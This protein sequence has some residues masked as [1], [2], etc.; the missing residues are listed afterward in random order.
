M[1][2]QS[3]VPTERIVAWRRH[4]HQNPELSHQEN[5]TAAYIL[6]QLAQ[7][8]V[9]RIDRPT[10]TSLIATIHGA[11]PGKT[12][13]FRADIDALPIEEETGLPFRS[14]VPGVMHACGHDG[15]AA[16]LLG[17]A[18]ML[19]RLRDRFR[20]TAKLLF[21]HAEEVVPSGASQIIETGALE[22]V[23]ACFGMHLFPNEIPGAIGI[24]P[25]GPASSNSD[26][27]NVKI[28]GKGTHGSMPHQGVDPIL[29]ASEIILA[30]NTIV[31]RNISPRETAVVSIGAIHAGSA[32]N[33]IPDLAEIRGNTR[34][35]NPETRMAIKN[36]IESIIR[37]VCDANDAKY[38]LDFR[39]GVESIQNDAELAALAGDAC[40]KVLGE[41]MV[42]DAAPMLA[43]EDF[44]FYSRIVPTCFIF[45]GAGNEIGGRAYANHHPK[46]DI[47]EEALPLGSLAQVQIILDFLK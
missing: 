5:Q 30:L 3:S 10:A 35:M 37:S 23:D 19:C 11:G 38:E 31:S 6:E 18:D 2:L 1:D 22:G 32:N 39:F 24:V 12:A 17:T 47:R 4:I 13:L 40:R 25:S 41:E 33:I 26:L 9:D 36:R 45:L 15:H 27:F 14:S 29:V 7:I 42:Y 46:F 43:S 20:G 44:A 21:Q 16:M 34:S 8:G 28:Y